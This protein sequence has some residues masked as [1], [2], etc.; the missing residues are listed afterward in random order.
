MGLVIGFLHSSFY[1][2][3]DGVFLF[4]SYIGSLNFN[5]TGKGEAI[6]GMQFNLDW[7]DM[8][9]NFPYLVTSQSESEMHYPKPIIVPYI[10]TS[11]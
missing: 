10:H 4:F 6:L 3:C 8:K 5:L 1:L 7:L 9:S 2:H 11:Y